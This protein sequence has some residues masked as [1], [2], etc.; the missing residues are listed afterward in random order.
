MKIG[1]VIHFHDERF[2]EGAVQLSWV[3]RR[4][5]QASRAAEAFV[6]HGPRYHGAGEA[7]REGI[8]RAYKLK[9]TASFVLD[10][11]LGSFPIYQ[12]CP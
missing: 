10:L 7:E 1:Q 2:F 11:L 8:D 6:F 12:I 4:V 5:D 9:D 3:Q